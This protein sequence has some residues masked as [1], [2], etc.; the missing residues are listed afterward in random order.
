MKFVLLASLILH[1]RIMTN[2]FLTQNYF[3]IEVFYDVFR[4]Q[5]VLLLAALRGAS[6]RI[7]A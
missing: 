2:S 4:Q 7:P 3:E 5:P 6:Y 1:V